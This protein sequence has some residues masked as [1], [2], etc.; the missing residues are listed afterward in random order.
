LAAFGVCSVDKP[1][2]H[3]NADKVAHTLT[4]GVLGPDRE[5]VWG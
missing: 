2:E 1:G 4:F 3:E 5:R